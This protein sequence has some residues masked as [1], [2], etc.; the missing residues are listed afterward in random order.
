[1]FVLFL[2]CSYIFVLFCFFF[3]LAGGG[4]HQVSFEM[5]EIRI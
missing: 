4:R 2:V 3:L 1:L 5:V